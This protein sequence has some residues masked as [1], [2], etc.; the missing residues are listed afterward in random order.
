MGK[1]KPQARTKTN[2][3]ATPVATLRP[4]RGNVV[5]KYNATSVKRPKTPRRQ[6]RKPCDHT[7]AVLTI[8]IWPVTP[9]RVRQAAEDGTAEVVKVLQVHFSDIKR[10][11]SGP[12]RAGR[13]GPF[14]LGSLARPW[15][16]T[17]QAEKTLEVFQG[18]GQKTG[19]GCSGS[20]SSGR[21]APG[22]GS[23]AARPGRAVRCR[24]TSWCSGPRGEGAGRQDG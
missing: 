16:R 17:A 7:S 22:S 23:Q 8:T 24:K 18:G 5:A 13:G 6:F 21:E 14:G 10:A 20:R 9:Q 15:P 19:R 3:L 1:P 11:Y 4:Q 12:G 2:H